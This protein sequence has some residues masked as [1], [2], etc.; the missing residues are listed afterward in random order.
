[1][2]EFPRITPFGESALLV[3]LGATIEPALNARVHVLADRLDQG[4]DGLPGLGR[5]VPAYASLLVPFE[6]GSVDVSDLVERLGELATRAEGE[7]VSGSLVEIA[8]MYGYDDGPDLEEVA[9]LTGISAD[10]VIDQHVAA[11]YRVYKLGFA[12][13]FAYLGPLPETLRV[14][15]RAEPRVRVPAGSVAVAGAQTA[16]YP[17]QT[18]GG[19]HLIGRTEERLWD[20]SADEPA[21]L[22]PGDRVRFVPA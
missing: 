13:G 11:E 21:R 8:V 12:P 7:A 5:C 19:W 10:A 14:P 20:P 16:V 22:R 17:Q 2:T 6:P 15:R 1:M 3:E 4:V 9:R 18:A